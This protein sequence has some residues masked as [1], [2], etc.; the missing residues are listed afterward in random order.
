V[1]TL[2]ARTPFVRSEAPSPGRLTLVALGIAL[3]ASLLALGIGTVAVPLAIAIGG[4]IG[5]IGTLTLA[6]LRYDAAVALGLLLLGIVRIEPAPVDGVFAVVIAV[7][8]V[9]GRLDLRAAPKWILGLLGVFV[10]LNLLACIEAEKPGRAVSFMSITFYCLLLA[11]WVSGY[12]RSPERARTFLKCYVGVALVSAVV[13][14]LA[15]YVGFPGS[16]LL[17]EFTPPR[18]RG[19]FKDPNVYG[20]FEVVATVLVLMELIEPRLLR[21]RAPLKLAMLGILFVGVFFAYS[22]AAYLNLVVAVF[23]L[24]LVLPLRRGGTKRAVGLLVAALSAAAIVGGA[25]AVTGS[26][27]FLQERAKFQTYDNQRFGAQQRG[28]QLAQRYPIG[29]GPGQFESLAPISAHS[30]YVRTVAE[31]GILGF[32]ILVGVIFGTLLLAARNVIVGR[33]TYGIGSTALLAAWCGML[34][35]SLFIDSLHWRHLWIVAG[36]IW[37]GAL[38]DRFPERQASS[39]AGLRAPT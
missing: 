34:A 9:T 16:D 7:A 14:T 4:G 10:A 2:A 38:S 8:I 21:L 28:L 23:V 18:A 32:F 22:R 39:N 27:S 29:I 17:K 26:L 15:L 1:P 13:S 11:V 35:N 33:G 6:L 24:L 20:P 30:T 25:V 31:E 36:L 12:V 19:L 5:L 37:A 3:L